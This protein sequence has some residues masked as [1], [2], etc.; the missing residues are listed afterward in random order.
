ME[1]V[2]EASIDSTLVWR[3]RLEGLHRRVLSSRVTVIVAGAG[4]GKSTLLERWSES[5]PATQLSLDRA[6]GSVTVLTRRISDALRLRVPGL[7]ADLAVGPRSGSDAGSVETGRAS[8]LASWLADAL[9]RHL[10][11]PVVLMLDDIDEIDG[12]ESVALVHALIGHAPAR[13]RV[14][15]SGRADPPLRLARLRA[16]SEVLDLGSAELAFTSQETEQLAGMIVGERGFSHARQVQTLTGGWPVAT[17]LALEALRETGT[18]E[19]LTTA[20]GPG[21]RLFEYLAEEVFAAST[22]EDR[23]R[24]AKLAALGGFDLDLCVAA[25]IDIL[26]DWLETLVRRGIYF[27]ST[28][29]EIR[30]RPLIARFVRAQ[31]G[32]PPE[33]LVDLHRRAARWALEHHDGERALRQAMASDDESMIAEVAEALGERVLA[34]GG[35]FTVRVACE[36][37]SPGHRAPVLT[38]MLGDAQ[39]M[40]GDWDSALDSFRSIAGVESNIDPGLAWRM[41][42]ILYLRGELSKAVACYRRADPTLGSVADRSLLAGWWGAAA[43]VTGAIEECRGLAHLAWT[44][45][46]ESGDDRAMANALTVRAMLAAVDGDR[47]ANET[48]YL[49]A[50]EHAERAGDVL[51]LIRIHVNRG[52]RHLEEGGYEE[53]IAETDIALRLAALGGFTSL[54]ALGMNNRG[55]AWL[56]LG[57]LEEAA[58]DFA[59]AKAA[60]DR[61][62]SK[63]VAYALVATGDVHR[64]RGDLTLARAAYEEARSV[65]EP[66]ND[67][68]AMVPALSGLARVMVFDDPDGALVAAEQAVAAGPVLG[69]VGALLGAAE[70]HLIRRETAEAIEKA[71]LALETARGRRDRAGMAEALELLAAGGDDPAGRLDEAISIWGELGDVVARARARL[72]LTALTGGDEPTV[73]ELRSIFRRLGVRRLAAEAETLLDE[74]RDNR[75]PEVR[76]RTLGGFGVEVRGDPVAAT[77]WQSKKARDVVKILVARRGRPIHSEELVEHLWPEESPAKT[78]NRLSVALSVV[79]GVFDP[80]KRHPPDHFLVGDREAVWL[81]LDRMAVDLEEFHAAHTQGLAALRQGEEDRALALF[82]QAE[83]AYVGDLL[84]E[85]PYEEWAVSAREEARNAYMTVARRLG[86]HARST[87][88]L[89]GAARYLLRVLQRDPYDERAHL[90]LVSVMTDGSRHGEARRLYDRYSQRME[91]IGVEP[92][93]F[94]R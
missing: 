22:E 49:K 15:V 40:L 27:E 77:V 2:D 66:V 92:A 94:P 90:A 37:V 45:A 32:P 79:R 67:F 30:V 78:G 54:R 14:V 62:G 85:D 41:G 88:D 16:R 33:E 17:R 60:W 1:P 44:L 59:E 82:E 80:D 5:L 63:Q 19:I 7:T 75:R 55:Q 42:L 35:A 56:R 64:T 86:E 18:A 43:W 34:M 50:L 69:R 89:D 26:P 20:H 21:G 24:L 13:L 48:L 57:R 73:L 93:P 58:S 11:R 72:R 84:E 28:G 46:T 47:R 91:E 4:Y 87:G 3:P 10:R 52:S 76:V 71:R 65:A 38:R 36:R 12:S 8:A 29:S 9:D 25:G 70:V 31:Y 61:V 51:Q 83:A 74:L 68:Q 39:Q 23:R 53:S 6:D 81:R